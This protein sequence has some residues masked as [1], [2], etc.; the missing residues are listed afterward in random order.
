MSWSDHPTRRTALLALG[1]LAA[2]GFTPVL[3]PDGPGAVLLDATAFTAPDTEIGFR[4]R[5]R[6]EDRLGRASAPRYAL[7]TDLDIGRTSAAITPAG[8]ITRI[9]LSGEATF[10][11]RASA[12]DATIATGQV[13]S[14]TSY[15][16]TGTTVATRAAE[17][18]AGDR[19]ATILADLIVTRLLATPL[20]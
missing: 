11:L 20:P 12:T 3:A 14:F 18:D 6:L 13:E 16:T 4:L 8:D 2:C 7:S 15:S 5:A 1:G 9:T 10:T 19:L 17:R